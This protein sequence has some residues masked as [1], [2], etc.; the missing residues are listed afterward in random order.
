MLISPSLILNPQ[1]LKISMHINGQLR[2]SSSTKDMIF[3]VA[4]LISFL[5]Q[6]TTLAPGTVIL[7]GTPKGVIGMPTKVDKCYLSHDDVMQV[8]IE[9]IGSLINTIKQEL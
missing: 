6:G 3:S 8:D 4:S 2:Q 1:S 9:G 7:T 5:S